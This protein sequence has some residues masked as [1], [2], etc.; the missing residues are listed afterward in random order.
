MNLGGVHFLADARALLQNETDATCDQ[1]D[2]IFTTTTNATDD[3]HFDIVLYKTFSAVP[4]V[5]IVVV[6]VPCACQT[7]EHGAPLG[8]ATYDADWKR[9]MRTRLPEGLLIG[10]IAAMVQHLTP[11]EY[12][13]AERKRVASLD[14]HMAVVATFK[15]TI[16]ID[17]YLQALM[18]ELRLRSRRAT[19]VGD[20][21]QST[22]RAPSS[23]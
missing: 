9:D 11:F 13:A 7:W 20:R 16:V 2:E 10:P 6:D 8:F 17:L 1:V 18:D 19:R 5:F 23:S 22:L 4:A 12:R 14:S 3:L 21:T 15:A